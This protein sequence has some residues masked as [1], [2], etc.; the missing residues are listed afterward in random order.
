MEET[1]DTKEVVAETKSAQI[2][3]EDN[4]HHHLRVG[5]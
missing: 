5:D 2:E 4:A 1:K 3:E